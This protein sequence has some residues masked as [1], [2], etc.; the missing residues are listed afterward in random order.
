METL[1]IGKTGGRVAAIGNDVIPLDGET[2]VTLSPA[3]PPAP[4]A[5]PA[6]VS[7]NPILG[8]DERDHKIETLRFRLADDDRRMAVLARDLKALDAHMFKLVE[9]LNLLQE[10]RGEMMKH[11]ERFNTWRSVTVAELSRLGASP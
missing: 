4:A 1:G 8:P 9:R 2:K 5:D 3:P 7:L 10:R 11:M 6:V